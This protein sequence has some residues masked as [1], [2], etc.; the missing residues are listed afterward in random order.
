MVQA[1]VQLVHQQLQLSAAVQP[2]SLP[3]GCWHGSTGPRPPLTS[4]GFL[5]GGEGGIIGVLDRRG[6]DVHLVDE[7]GIQLV[8]QKG[9]G[10]QRKV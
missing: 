3:A 2:A 6:V 4:K 1:H 10:R 9:R 5:V 8:R 7:R